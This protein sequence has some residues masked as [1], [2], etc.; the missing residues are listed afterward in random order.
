MRNK[1]KRKYTLI[2]LFVL[3]IVAF[4]GYTLT[5]FHG[6]IQDR[7]YKKQIETMKNN[8][9][10]GSAVVEKKLGGLVN[11]LYGLAEY[12]QEDDID[13]NTNIDKLRKFLEKR[14]V[15]FQR[16]GIAHTNGDAK[17]TNGERLNISDREYFQICIKE[18]KATTEIRQSEITDETIC[19]VAVPILG[20]NNQSMGVLYGIT[21]LSAFRIYDD[22]ILEDKNQFIQIVDMDGNYI[23]KQESSL[24]GKKDN[25]FDG[26]SSIEG[27]DTADAI[28]E[29]IQKEEQVYT[30]VSDGK[31]HEILYFTPLKLNDWCIVTVIDY[32]EVAELVD[33]ILEDDTYVMT[34]KVILAI[35]L[36]ALLIMYYSWQERKQIKEFNE[37]L[38]MDEKIVSIAAEK[39]G[40][41]IMSYGVKS[42]QL[43]FINNVMRNMEFPKQ[44]DNAPEE[45]MKYI[46]E[47]A[48]LREQIRKIFENITHENGK[49]RIPLELMWGGRKVYL[50]IQLIPLLVD[51]NGEV[52]QYIGVMEDNTEKQK[53]RDKADK[54]AL[55]GL[56]NRNSALE[57]IDH[58]IKDSQ[59]QPGEVHAYMIMDLDNFKTLNDTLGHQMGDKAL[60]DVAEILTRH[61]RSYDVICRLGG[62]EFLVFMKNIP[63]DVVERNVDSLLR[64]LALTY[65]EGGK[66]VQI[67]AS[68]GIVLISD[69]DV[70]LSKMYR[71]A[72]EV[73]YQIK[74]ETKNGFKIFRQ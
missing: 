12:V 17:I 48:K 15:G 55:T 61:F 64:K 67:T 13:S 28:R 25:I 49:R 69:T 52:R 74:H 4:I 72:D 5:Q 54:D 44:I 16:I 65:E 27:K 29:Q 51:S 35:T 10:Q 18:K 1:E 68:A 53:L 39:S 57:K 11:T 24:I 6:D 14:D 50:N 38:V 33:Y 31:Y 23:R 56:Y 45:I 3:G 20:D 47:D 41:V 46:P 58:C 60:Q 43:R 73:L 40:F 62:D 32:E 26:I 42:K 70:D 36:L 8:S 22:T 2:F 7:V 19:I 21:E 71:E 66:N 59:L 9:M 34:L 63:E 37:K 30:E